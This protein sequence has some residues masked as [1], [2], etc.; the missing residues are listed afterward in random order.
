[1][2]R[3]RPRLRRPPT[4]RTFLA[5]GLLAACLALLAALPGVAAPP[6]ALAACSLHNPLIAGADPSVWYANGSYYLA[7]SDGTTIVLR[8]APTVGGLASAAPHTVWTPPSGTDHSAQVWA[9]EI[10][11]LNGQWI[12]YFAA[13]TDKGSFNATNNMHRLFALTATSGNPLGAWSFFGKVQD[14]TNEW[15]IDPTVFTYNGAWYELW[16]GTSPGNGGTAP[17]QLYIAHMHDPLHVD[18]AYRKLIANPDQSWETSR[19]A[20]EEGPEAFI[21]PTGQLTI[22]YSANASWTTAY[23]LG[24]LRY[25]GGNIESYTGYAK[26]GPVFASGGGVYGP[27]HVSLPVPGPNG[28]LWLV[29]HA[30]TQQADGWDDRKIFAQPQVWNGNGTPSFGS[31]AGAI[32]FDEQTQQ[33]C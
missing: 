13:A 28:H 31:P 26:A 5:R 21:A 8:A 10:E 29:Y 9:P 30:K 15:A 33:A 1:M 6:R 23:T 17:Q 7:Q 27:G 18:D 25:N 20:I 24:E 14:P 4:R 2:D 19:A 3:Y 12:I 11:N 16:S 22:V 32:S